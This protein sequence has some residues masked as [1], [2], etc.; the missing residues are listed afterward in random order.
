[1]LTELYVDNFRCLTN[2][3]INPGVFQLWSGDN[4][5]GK[6][7]VLHAM[8]NVQRL[9]RGEHVGDIFEEDSTTL[10]D[11]RLE[12][13]VGLS[14]S[15]DGETY[16]YR[17]IVEYSRH[18]AKTRI[19]REQMKWNDE[20]FFLYDAGEAHL[21]RINRGTGQVEEGV[22]FSA[23]WSRSV[24]PS[25]AERDDNRPLV[26]FRECVESWLLVHPVPLVMEEMARGE[27]RALSPHL[28]NFA[29]WY[30]H[31]LQERPEIGR[32]ANT[33]IA[34]A[35]PGFD[36]LSL[37]DIG[38]ARR[39]TAT[40]RI[41]GSNH[42]FDFLELSDGQRQIIALYTVLESLRAGVFSAIFVDEPDNFVS[43]REIRPWLDCLEG[44]CEEDNRQAVIISHHP[45]IV[46]AMARGDDL[47]FS[48]PGGAHVQV[49]PLPVTPG[50]TPAETVARGWGDE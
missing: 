38:E 31:L 27:M 3:R 11:T 32:R 14:L 21:F 43:L 47:W 10:W 20:T 1:M 5:S 46:N 42:E 37:K 29:Q 30:R 50:L 25:I 48:R 40:F 18:G 41:D 12:Q 8:R 9:L 13:T 6:T 22:R 26:K 19:K 23:D 36:L 33:L 7:S 2:F 49:K 4:G 39:L 17:L 16:E 45:E 24:I 44:L 35:L 28:E 15:I 34:E